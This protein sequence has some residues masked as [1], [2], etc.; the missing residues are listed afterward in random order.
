MLPPRRRL[1]NLN[2]RLVASVLVV[3]LPLAALAG[4]GIR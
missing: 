2:D 1:K 4:R 3:R